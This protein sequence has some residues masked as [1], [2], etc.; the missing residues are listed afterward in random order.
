MG[1]RQGKVEEMKKRSDPFVT[2]AFDSYN[3]AE[4]RLEKLGEEKGT[5]IP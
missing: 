5:K 2:L 1:E 4:A 3:Q